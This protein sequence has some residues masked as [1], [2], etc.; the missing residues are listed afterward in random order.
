MGS[1]A[2]DANPRLM[3][4]GESQGCRSCPHQVDALD[5]AMTTGGSTWNTRHAAANT[6]PRKTAPVFFA[7]RAN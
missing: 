6:T 7:N 2:R 3:T 1:T 4:C 5:P